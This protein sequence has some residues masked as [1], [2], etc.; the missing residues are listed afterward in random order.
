MRRTDLKFLDYQATLCL[1]KKAAG[2]FH[3]GDTENLN[4]AS[5]RKVERF[6]DEGEYSIL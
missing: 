5:C 2:S 1:A 3:A 4:E 6:A